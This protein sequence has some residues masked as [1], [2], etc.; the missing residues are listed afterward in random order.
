MNKK[1]IR[2]EI[3]ALSLSVTQAMAL[4]EVINKIKNGEII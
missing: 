1:E 3:K 2:A 4:E